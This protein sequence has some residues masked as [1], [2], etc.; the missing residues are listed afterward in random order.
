MELTLMLKSFS[1]EKS[2]DRV[3]NSRRTVRTEIYENRN[4]TFQAF[5][6]YSMDKEE[7]VVGFGESTSKKEAVTLSKAHL[8]QQWPEIQLNF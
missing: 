2:I 1:L 5:S 6:H 4:G 8:K 3:G 7:R